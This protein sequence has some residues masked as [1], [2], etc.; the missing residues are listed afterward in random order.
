M[1]SHRV[2]STLAWRGSR[3]G[4]EENSWSL[5]HKHLVKGVEGFSGSCLEKGK[6]SALSLHPDSSSS[7]SLALG[8]VST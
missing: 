3:E 5:G 7:A 1:R 8:L 6:T 2:S 4:F